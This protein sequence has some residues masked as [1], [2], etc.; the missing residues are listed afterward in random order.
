MKIIVGMSGGVDSAVTAALLKQQG[1][2]VI[3]VTMS[4]W[5]EGSR[6]KG[7][8][9]NGCFGPAQ[10]QSIPQ[11][12]EISR[13]LGIPYYDFDCSALYEAQVV[14]YF[15]NEYLSGRTPNP[16]IV[17][18]S[19]VKFGLLPQ[20]AR[21]NGINFDKFATGHYAKVSLGENGRYQIRR[22]SEIARDQSYF[23]CRLSQ[24]QL[25]RHLFPLG[26]YHKADVRQLAR[27]FLLPVSE[28][29][30]SQ[31]FYT[32]ELEELLGQP[33]NV[34]DIIDD[35]T[36][37]VLGH[38]TGCWKYT[39]GQRRGL[40]VASTQPLYV[41]AIDA[42]HNQIRLGKAAAVR[43]HAL[44]ADNFNWVS[45]E[46]PTN[47]F[48]ASLKVRSV[49]TPVKCLCTPLNDNVCDIEFPD[50]ISGVAPGQAAVLYTDDL[51]L[52]GGTITVSK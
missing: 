47:P 15:R 29:H 37:K 16:C 9:K 22:A 11:S 49:Q 17:C 36:G 31:D 46:P 42:C 30:D 44:T 39:I 2:D 6:F 34:G 10:L 43:H 38:H 12:R 26:D 25:A 27:Q 50:G 23:L 41:V 35:E 33:E 18:N 7:G 5:H 4:I 24:E 1:H 45:I 40:G 14:E 21:E 19:V 48:E 32:G 52:G 13:I 51:L 28:K 3:G 20:L 8:D